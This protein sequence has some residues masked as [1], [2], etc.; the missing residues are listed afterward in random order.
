MDKGLIGRFEDPLE[1]LDFALGHT[2]E[3]GLVFAKGSHSTGLHRLAKE[4][5]GKKHAR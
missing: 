4:F 3:G 5:S 1:A 2:P